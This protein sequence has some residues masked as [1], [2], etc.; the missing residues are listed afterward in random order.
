MSDQAATLRGMVGQHHHYAKVVT[1]ASGKGG[2]GKSNII[3]NVAIALAGL[4]L[5]IALFDMDLGLANIDIL[6]GM[7]PHH[8]LSHVMAGQK[9]LTD[10]ILPGPNNVMIIPGAS[11]VSRLANL[12]EQERATLIESF[13]EIE[14]RADLLLVDTGAG[15]S[16]NVLQF[17]LASQVLVVVTTPEPTAR[18]DAYALIKTVHRMSEG[19]LPI[20]VIVNG[21]AS[22]SEAEQVFQ[23]LLAVCERHLSNHP[24][25][26][27]FVPQDPAIPKAVKKRRPFLLN[28]PG[29]PAARAVVDLAAEMRRVLLPT[30]SNAAAPRVANS[31]F[32]RLFSLFSSR[33]PQ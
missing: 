18:M 21:V 3:V 12:K 24:Q 19:A 13:A 28:N 20:Q 9:S 22:K 23:S 16:D 10:I 11:G 4:D 17:A 31:F 15:I 1:F 8:N 5:K 33:S 25:F 30:G 29:S 27:G 32:A 2:V 26:L 14:A 6:L 7:T